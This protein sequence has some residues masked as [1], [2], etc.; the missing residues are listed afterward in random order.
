MDWILS[1]IYWFMAFTMWGL[2]WMFGYAVGLKHRPKQ[3]HCTDCGDSWDGLCVDCRLKL[4]GEM[5]Q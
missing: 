3:R 4:N 2:G 1:H 5:A